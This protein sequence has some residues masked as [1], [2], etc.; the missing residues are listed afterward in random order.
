MIIFN[1]DK[2]KK[3]HDCW[4]YL[5]YDN[6]TMKSKVILGN[7]DQTLKCDNYKIYILYKSK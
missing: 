5:S 7:F 4:I 1:F 3:C 2:K 6:K